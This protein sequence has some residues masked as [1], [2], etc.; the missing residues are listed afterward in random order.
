M[1]LEAAGQ[2]SQPAHPVQLASGPISQRSSWSPR[3]FRSDRSRRSPRNLR[4]PRNPRNTR[5]TR[6]PRHP[7]VG[8]LGVV[9]PVAVLS[10]S[11]NAPV[12]TVYMI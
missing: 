5:N 11:E 8:T 6:S 1:A 12:Q 3:N 4:N 10:N 9:P 2:S 7:R